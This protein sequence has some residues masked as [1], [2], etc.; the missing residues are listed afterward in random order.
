[1]NCKYQRNFQQKVVK[2]SRYSIFSIKLNSSI[3]KR[4]NV[5]QY[6]VCSK[7]QFIAFKLKLIIFDDKIIANFIAPAL[8]NVPNALF[9]VWGIAFL[10]PF[11]SLPIPWFPWSFF[12]LHLI[13]FLAIFFDSLN[14]SSSSHNLLFWSPIHSFRF[15][16]RLLFCY[17]KQQILHRVFDRQR[18][19]V[20]DYHKLA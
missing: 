6:I 2:I 17:R 10:I 15:L 18:M 8:G 7:T 19:S 20:S 12:E 5:N 16:I 13:H 1:M 3:M 14:R 9:I 4:V 11:F